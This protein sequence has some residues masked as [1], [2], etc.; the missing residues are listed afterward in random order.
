MTEPPSGD[1]IEIAHG[2]QRAVV[3]ELA[4]DLRSDQVADGARLDGYGVDAMSTSGRGQVLMP[5]PNRLEGGSY[6]FRGRRHQLPLDEPEA[7][8]AIHGFVRWESWT[9]AERETNR[10]VMRHE[11]HPRPGYPFSLD[12]VIEYSLSQA[13]LRVQTT[14]TNVGGEPCPFGSGAHP[15]LTIGTDRVDS[16]VLRVPART[17]LHAN[18]HGIP[19]GRGAV[20]GT[21]HDFQQARPIGATQLDHAFTDLERDADGIA[22]VELRRPDAELGLALWVDGS[23]RWL[24][25][26]TGDPLPDVDRRS[27][28]V[29]PM[30]CPPNAFRSTEDLIVLGAR[31]FLRRYLG[32]EPAPQLKFTV[33]ER[34]SGL[35]WPS[36][37]TTTAY[38]RRPVPGT[39]SRSPFCGSRSPSAG[40]RP[41]GLF[42]S[43]MSARRLRRSSSRRRSRRAGRGG[44]PPPAP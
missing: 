11:V 34:P 26:F 6:D 24:M 32:P 25:L 15:Y 2:E 29:E 3:V 22:R 5:W 41:S 18:A 38:R 7:G 17:V 4:G 35:P 43:A 40:T 20:H 27:L 16:V 36:S 1:Q 37:A 30:T 8:N 23:Y 21:E 39:P 33:F 9:V 31:Q 13:G 14:A 28:A 19:T 12:L 10:V 44:R 42:R